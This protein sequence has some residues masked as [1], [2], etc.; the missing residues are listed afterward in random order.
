[1]PGSKVLGPTR[2]E[3]I[4]E[5]TVKVRRKAELPDLADWP[6]VPLSRGEA[7]S[8]Y[9]AE[10]SD[11]DLVAKVLTAHGLTLKGADLA[12]RNIV[13]SGPI[14]ALESTFRTKL[15]RYDHAQGQYR[16]RKGSLNVPSELANVIVGIYGLDNRRVI[17]RR[18]RRFK[19]IA[20]LAASTSSH[21]GFF[22]SELAELYDFPQ[23]TGAGESIGILE[24]GGGF[25]PDD[26]EVFCKRV[27]VGIP[28]VV[29]V[30]VNHA[31]TNSDDDAVGE[32][33]L[34]IEIVAGVCPEA[35]IPVY[36]GP[37]LSERSLI[38][39]VDKAIHDNRHKPAVLSISWGDFE[40]SATWS[41]G[42]LDRVNDAFHEA[43]L[44]GITICVAAGDDGSDDGAGDGH[45]HVD[46]P[47]SSPFVLAVGG[48]DLR[49]DISGTTERVWKD[50]D[51]RRPA[52]GG[53]GGA[54]G[55]GVS[56]HF[57]RPAFQADINIASVNPAAIAGRVVPDV[58][59]HAQTDGRTTGYV[60]VLHGAPGLNGG[61]SA[62]APLW[63][64]LI[65]RINAAIR[66]TKG[67]N[68][69]VGYLTP[70][71]YKPVVGGKALGAWASRDITDGDNISATIGGYRAG[72]G[73]DAVTGWGSPIGSKLLTA[74][75]QII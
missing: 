46:F 56:A 25:L 67:P 73:Y 33:M 51:G 24:F 40:E 26:L 54:T 71:L 18:R 5:I 13:F 45:A 57:P 72:A 21:R 34:D 4:L 8:A 20:S 36:F 31:P 69:R 47:S 48:T 53:T 68:A 61:T 75:T 60:V 2:P 66:K 70:L 15:L 17:R 35:T 27:G 30:S 37:D 62:S 38:D 14:S 3:E 32:V 58:A 22:P 11:V 39:T 63:A 28:Q 50:G 44:M 55:G 52:I 74:L 42:T 7:A 49:E 59:A 12:T 16:G 9:G 6:K 43:A 1:M 29:P 41:D 10:Q 65:G 64:A 19:E 23:G